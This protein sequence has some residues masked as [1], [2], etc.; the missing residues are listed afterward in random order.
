VRFSHVGNLNCVDC[1][2]AP[3]N[4][5]GSSCGDCHSTRTWTPDQFIHT[6]NSNCG[7]CHTEPEGHYPGSC[8]V[9]HNVRGWHDANWALRRWKFLHD[10]DRRY[11]AKGLGD[12]F[13]IHA[14]RN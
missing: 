3:V 1:H 4:H 10:L 2:K 11:A 14:A 12:W 9:C 13:D 7:S 6:T 8:T 5:Y